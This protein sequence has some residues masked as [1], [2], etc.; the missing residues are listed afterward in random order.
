MVTQMSHWPITLPTT[1][2]REKANEM[3]LHTAIVYAQNFSV[4]FTL[5]KVNNTSKSLGQK[6]QS[7]VLSNKF[8][9]FFLFKVFHKC[10]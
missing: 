5:E 3:R 8:V 7:S 2:S 6:L 4:T 1:G 9:F 10:V